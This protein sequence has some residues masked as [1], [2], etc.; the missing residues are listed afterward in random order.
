[1]SVSM[2]RIAKKVRWGLGGG[3]ILM[4]WGVFLSGVTGATEEIDSL[5]SVQTSP[6]PEMALYR[7]ECGACHL[8]YP[9][10]LLP[11]D[12]WDKL[13]GQLDN[14]FGENA[15]TDDQ[16]TASIRRYLMSHAGDYGN[17]FL[18]GIAA[19]TAPLRIT[20]L[21]RFIRKHDEIPDRM[22]KDNPK[23]GSFT[24]CSVCHDNAINGEFDEDTVDIPGF[25]PWDD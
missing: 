16:T 25:G 4:A 22:V 7:E 19:S 1:M 8:A 21:P 2:N 9:A 17:G 11:A 3:F 6:L 12:S 23:V 18:R 24:D 5:K 13:M 14:H 20:E 10:K 15:E